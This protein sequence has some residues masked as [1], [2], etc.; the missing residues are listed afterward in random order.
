M[1]LIGISMA[2]H[3]LCEAAG[4][5]QL[6]RHVG[7]SPIG[8]GGDMRLLVH[9]QHSRQPKVRQLHSAQPQQCGSQASSNG[10]AGVRASGHSR[11]YEAPVYLSA[12]ADTEPSHC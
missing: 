11:L 5:Q 2:T 12:F 9:I 1:W 6:W 8:L 10:D 7:H 3:R 4:R